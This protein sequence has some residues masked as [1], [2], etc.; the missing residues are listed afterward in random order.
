MLKLLSQHKSHLKVFVAVI[1]SSRTGRRD[2]MYAIREYLKRGL[3]FSLEVLNIDN[4]TD[5][6][7]HI[8]VAT[9]TDDKCI[10]VCWGNYIQIENDVS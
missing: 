7:L 2:H 10:K 6:N 5:K 4:L 3:E 8:Y 1:T 9:I